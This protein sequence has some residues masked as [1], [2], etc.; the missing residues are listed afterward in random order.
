MS[1]I[2][3]SN[4]NLDKMVDAVV[5]EYKPTNPDDPMSILYQFTHTSGDSY[6]A[7]PTIL[8]A[9]SHTDAGSRVFLYENQY[10]PSIHPNKPDW[11][12]CEHGDD[13]FMLWGFPFL[14]ATRTVKAINYSKEDEEVTLEMMA[15]WAN[16]ARTGDPSDSTGGPTD[17]PSLPTWPQYTP[18]NP[19][20]MKLD[21][22]PT[23]EVGY[24]PEKMKL[25]NEVIPQIAAEKKDEL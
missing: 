14:E 1:F 5:A 20:Y 2:H 4:P 24:K 15:Y 3:H 12:G 6:F 21:V 13:L 19:V 25:W 17:S 16:F 9:E 8:V 18:D 11:V 23:T 22:V 10:R 7:A